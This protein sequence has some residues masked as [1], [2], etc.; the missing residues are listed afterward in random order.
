MGHSRR[1]SGTPGRRILSQPRSSHHQGRLHET[2]AKPGSADAI[3][4]WNTFDQLAN[5]HLVLSAARKLLRP[6]GILVVRV[7]NGEC[8]RTLITARQGW[9]KVSSRMCRSILAWNNLLGFPYLYGYTASTLD[10]LL[11]GYGMHR[12]RVYPDVLLPIAGAQHTTWARAEER[13]TK[14]LCRAFSHP[15]Q[16]GRRARLRLSPWCDYYYRLG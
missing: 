2:D 16:G 14:G 15:R 1:R 6:G 10:R 11:A 13:M 7:P 3:T 9:K 4:I 8:Y 5:P 12:L